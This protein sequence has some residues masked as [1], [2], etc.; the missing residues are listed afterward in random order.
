MKH[1][2]NSKLAI[3]SSVIFSKY[4]NS[5]N[6]GK[7]AAEYGTASL[8]FE[9]REREI[10]EEGGYGGVHWRDNEMLD[11]AATFLNEVAMFMARIVGFP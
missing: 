6:L 8:D 4:P 7:F 9:Q 11:P 2:P 10:R 1:L 5:E 3:S